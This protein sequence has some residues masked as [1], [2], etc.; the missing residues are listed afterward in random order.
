MSS[1][2]GGQTFPSGCCWSAH[3]KALQPN[4]IQIHMFVAVSP[5]ARLTVLAK[6]PWVPCQ[7]R[8]TPRT[9]AASTSLGQPLLVWL[10]FNFF[11]KP[12]N[13]STPWSSKTDLKSCKS[14]PKTLWSTAQQSIRAWL[15]PLSCLWQKADWEHFFKEILGCLCNQRL[16]L[17]R[18]GLSSSLLLLS[19]KMWQHAKSSRPDMLLL[20]SSWKDEWIH[21][22]NQFEIIKVNKIWL[23]STKKSLKACYHVRRQLDIKLFCCYCI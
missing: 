21:Q 2:V 8:T 13:W 17:S 15:F 5:K 23:W 6:E 3:N 7:N 14:S 16:L 12:V 1:P 9:P 22:M 4:L 11:V 20:L 18:P 19:S 10:G